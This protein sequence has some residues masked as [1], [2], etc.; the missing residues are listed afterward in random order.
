MQDTEIVEEL[1]VFLVMIESDAKRDVERALPEISSR[2][3]RHLSLAPSVEYAVLTCTEFLA[4]AAANS[5]AQAP[6]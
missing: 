3:E 5:N 6:R 1:P 2:L 4:L